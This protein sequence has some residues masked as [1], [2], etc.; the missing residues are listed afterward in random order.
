MTLPGNTWYNYPMSTSEPTFIGRGAQPISPP[1]PK[2]PGAIKEVF[3]MTKPVS[4]LIT[5]GMP[6]HLLEN[7][8]TPGYEFFHIENPTDAELA[9]AEVIVGF[10]PVSRLSAAVNLKWLQ[11]PWSGADGYADHPDFP[12]HVILT[13]ATGA[14]GRPIAEY[15]LA[16]VLTLMRRFHQYRDCQNKRLWQRQGDEMTPTGKHVLILGAGDIGS[17]AA[18]LFKTFGCTV[19]GV[20]RVVRQCPQDFDAMVTLEQAEEVLPKADIIICALPN[21]PLTRGYLDRRRLELLKSTAILVNVGRGTLLDHTA[22][23]ELLAEN[24]IYGAVLDVTDPEPLPEEHPLWKCSS[25]L[26]TPHVSGQTF[27]GLSHKEEYFFQ[28]CRENLNRYLA[29]EPL[30]NRVDLTTGYRV[31]TQ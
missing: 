19:T 5:G 7:I 12:G 17:H 11:I 30:V 29:G 10:P 21:T 2:A 26:I 15:A 9:R 8:Q 14:F 22:L 27:Q 16:G 31:T 20:R 18:R 6:L 1:A 25:A 4:V 24:R 13:N 23:A 3:F 28:V